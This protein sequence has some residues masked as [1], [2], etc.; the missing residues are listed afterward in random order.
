[1]CS[2]HDLLSSRSRID[3]KAAAKGK[4]RIR[5]AEAHILRCAHK[6]LARRP[7]MQPFTYR[8]F[9]RDAIPRHSQSA[10]TLMSRRQPSFRTVLLATA[11]VLLQAFAGGLALGESAAAAPLDAFGNPLCVTS[12]EHGSPAPA[13]HGHAR[14]PDC[15]ASGCA[16]ACGAAGPVPSAASWN[17][18]LSRPA[19]T[20]RRDFA[21]HLPPVLDR[22]P[23][24]P[25]G[26]PLTA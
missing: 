10:G 23:A 17:A 18:P 14:L 4:I 21:F 22:G 25:R 19:V 3:G 6:P 12:G 5:R 2:R 7:K 8:R 13:G 16:A 15:C 11:L 24:Q 26:P 9:S 1:M 20:G